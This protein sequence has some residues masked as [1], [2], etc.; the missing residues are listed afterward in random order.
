MPPNCSTR[1]SIFTNLDVENG[2]KTSLADPLRPTPVVVDR[3]TLNRMAL[4]A[5]SKGMPSE[6]K[7][8]EGLGGGGGGS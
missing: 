2:P 3:P 1:G 5:T 8:A 6:S 4:R 7:M